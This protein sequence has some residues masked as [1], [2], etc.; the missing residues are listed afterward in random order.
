VFAKYGFVAFTKSVLSAEFPAL[1]ARRGCL[2]MV[3]ATWKNIR[4]PPMGLAIKFAAYSAATKQL[5]TT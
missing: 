5:S 4:R 3:Y 1:G 2:I